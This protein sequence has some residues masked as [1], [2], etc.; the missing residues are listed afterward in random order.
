MRKFHMTFIVWSFRFM[1]IFHS[2]FV[3]DFSQRAVNDWFRLC[4]QKNTQNQIL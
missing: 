3:C 1:N 2:I 4:E